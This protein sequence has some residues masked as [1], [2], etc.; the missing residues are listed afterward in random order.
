M[1]S[2]PLLTPMASQKLPISFNTIFFSFVL[3]FWLISF[4]VALAADAKFEACAPRRCGM[5]PS[6]SYPFWVAE[7]QESYCGYLTFEVSCSQGHAVLAI[8]N[9][10]YIIRNISY[11][12]NSFILSNADLYEEKCPA[13]QHNFST[14][15]T[16]FNHSENHADL[17]LYYNCPSKPD[18]LLTFPIECA[19]NSSHY[20][21]GVFRREDLQETGY[22]LNSCETNINAPVDMDGTSSLEN[23]GNITYT[24]ILKTGFTLNWTANNC[25]GCEN[26]GG[27]CGF[28]NNE[29][30]C[31]CD[32][33]PH[34]K[35]CS[36]GSIRTKL[37]IGFSVGGGTALIMGVFFFIYLRR[38]K[39]SYVPSYF[40]RNISSDPSSITDPEK[41]GALYGVKFFTYDELE[42]A[43]DNFNESREI[44]DGGFGTVYLGKLK[45]GRTVAVKRLYENNYKRV[46][47][48]LNE[49]E[50]LT[51]LRHKNLVMLYGCTSRHSRELLLVYEYISNGTV[52][53]HLHGRN[54]EPGSLSWQTRL[55]IAVETASALKYLHASDIIHRDVKTHNILLDDNFNVKV[56]DFGLSRLFPLDVTHVSTC[57]QGTPG[58]VDPEYHQCYQLTDKSDVYSFGVV[59]VELISSKPAVDITRHRH[60]I[61]LSNMALNKIQND[62]L[63]ELV[64]PTLGFDKDSNTQKMITAVAELSFRCLQSDK[65][66]R[67]SMQ[68]VLEILTSI[69]CQDSQKAEEL[70]IFS[71]E[72]VLLK[73]G[74]LPLS[75]DSVTVKWISS[76]S[77]SN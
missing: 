4:N 15:R 44:G 64:D 38:R 67:P 30:V 62:A 39:A 49:V 40:T 20:S 25:S 16:L 57:P 33:G 37:I 55:K 58:Y 76:S 61:N 7:E 5:G 27:R 60:E 43:T 46:E 77:A 24:D 75:P 17:Y 69:Q 10:D 47:Q 72:F 73:S 48:F 6:I 18:P 28:D 1:V 11:S 45:D 2:S 8:S 9:D 52:A 68:E 14:Q 50:I 3:T 32:D 56:A 34:V 36:K 66:L 59:L 31:F 12:T 22:A 54:V 21:F 71:D 63:H 29:F 65:D 53:D 41:M 26:S 74:P 19:S 51:R 42:E 70:D 35:A 23:S 13:P